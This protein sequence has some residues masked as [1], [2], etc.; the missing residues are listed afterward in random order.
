MRGF[1]TTDTARSRRQKFRNLAAGFWKY[2]GLGDQ[3]KYIGLGD[4]GKYIGLGDQGKYILSELNSQVKQLVKT[5][6]Q[7]FEI[8]V[9][10]RPTQCTF[11]DC[12]NPMYFPWSPNP[13]YFPWSPKPNVLSL[14]AQTQSFK[15]LLML[16]ILLLLK[17][18]QRRAWVVTSAIKCHLNKSAW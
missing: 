8:S 18:V 15:L 2:I 16:S 5:Q 4:Q 6:Q 17:L 7:D 10:V 1:L 9:Y 14:I 13:M 11:P 12:P 3:G